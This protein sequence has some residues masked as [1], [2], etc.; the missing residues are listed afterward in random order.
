MPGLT[1]FETVALMLSLKVAL[2]SVIVCLPF[3]LAAAW[4]LARV[5]FVGKTFVDAIFH[6]PLVVPPVVVGYLMLLLLEEA[7]HSAAAHCFGITIAFTGLAPR[8]R[9]A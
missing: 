6:L 2:T 8:W 4:L 7:A 9:L 5:E 1:E 3:G